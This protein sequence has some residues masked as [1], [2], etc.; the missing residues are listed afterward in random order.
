MFDDN[1]FGKCKLPSNWNCIFDKHG[2]GV[3]RK[4]PLK[5]RKF[6]QLSSMTYQ[7]VAEDIVEAPKA[8]IGKI[9]IKLVKVPSSCD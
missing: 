6:L 8:Y 1:D 7:R 2:D 4:F 5:I 3:E 9:S